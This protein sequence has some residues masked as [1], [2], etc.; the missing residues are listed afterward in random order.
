MFQANQLAEILE[1]VYAVPSWL[2]GVAAT[3]L[4]ALVAFGGVERVGAV[5]SRLVP[6]MCLL[7]LLMGLAVLAVQYR[8]VPDVLLRIVSEAF[9]GAAIAGGATGIAFRQVVII[10]VKRAAFSNEAGLGTAALA[11]A[12]AKTREPVREGLVAMLGPFIDTIVICTITAL[13][14]LTSS[15]PTAGEVAGVSLTGRAFSNVL[16]PWAEDGLVLI[17]ALFAF[18]TMIGYAYYGQKCFAYLFGARRSNW[19]N[20]LYLAGLFLGASWSAGMVINLIDTAF[21]MMAWPNMIATL[22]LAPKVMAI[23]RDYLRRLDAAKGTASS[24]QAAT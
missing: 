1:G 3:V 12:A 8:Q 19:Y 9:G 15:T 4:V 6:L 23:T 14:I 13:V 22:I 18:T 7:Y 16:G 24:E 17:V 11:H 10:G 20:V 5:S 21:A 2:T